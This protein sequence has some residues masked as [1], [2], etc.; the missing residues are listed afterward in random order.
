MM[1]HVLYEYSMDQAG[2]TIQFRRETGKEKKEKQSDQTEVAI[3]ARAMKKS[4]KYHKKGRI[5][6]E[7]KNRATKRGRWKEIRRDGKIDRR[8]R[9]EG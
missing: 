9:G 2:C 4:V 7:N 3:T 6:D 1:E 8:R 5:K